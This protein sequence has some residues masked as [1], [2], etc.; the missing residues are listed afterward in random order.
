MTGVV[1]SKPD[2]H[3][4]VVVH[5]HFRH[6]FAE[7][8]DLVRGLAPGDTARAALVVDS[9]RFMLSCVEAHHRSEDEF[10]WPLLGT[11]TAEHAEAVERMEIQHHRL[12]D[13]IRQVTGALDELAANPR[14]TLCEQVATQL[15]ELRSL[16]NEHMDEEEKVILPL[17]ADYL[18]VAEWEELGQLSAAK[19]DRKYH[20]RAFSSLMAAA[21]PEEQRM[22]LSKVPKIAVVLWRLSGRRSYARLQAQLHGASAG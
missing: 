13:L 3:D 19:L 2:V 9:V 18:T 4:M 14:R 20:L 10:L 6:L 22:F 11:R 8:P 7:S 17:A 1:S 12:E 16:L 15:A 21:T 5:R